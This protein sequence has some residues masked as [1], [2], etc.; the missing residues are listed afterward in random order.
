MHDRVGGAQH[1]AWAWAGVEQQGEERRG[2]RRISA[3]VCMSRMWG[4][5]R[6]RAV[7][8]H[9]GRGSCQRAPPSAIQLVRMGEVG[10]AFQ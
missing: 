10:K 7:T 6:C 3:T 5:G 2:L 1:I 4:G 9:T 8:H